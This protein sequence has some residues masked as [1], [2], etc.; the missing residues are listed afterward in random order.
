MEWRWCMFL[1]LRSSLLTVTPARTSTSASF[2][3]RSSLWA[4][5]LARTSTCVRCAVRCWEA[6]TSWLDTSGPT[7]QPRRPCRPTRAPSVARRSAHRAPSTDTC[8]STQV[9]LTSRTAVLIHGAAA[10]SASFPSISLTVTTVPVN[11][12][13]FLDV[14]NAFIGNSLS[15]IPEVNSETC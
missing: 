1:C 7:T 8:W 13:H 4:V 3:F 10:K 12:I 6:P 5:T 9:G 14:R 15:W 11:R 2:S